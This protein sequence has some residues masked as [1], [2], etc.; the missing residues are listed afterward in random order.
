MGQLKGQTVGVFAPVR[1]AQAHPVPAD[2]GAFGFKPVASVAE[3]LA[4][5]FKDLKKKTIGI[6]TFQS[7]G[8]VVGISC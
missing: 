1:L 2:I 8:L 7:D 5:R 6:A 3:K 4:R